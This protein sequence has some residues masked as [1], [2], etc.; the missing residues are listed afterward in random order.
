ME[1][2]KN[3]ALVVGATGITGNNLAQ[4]LISQ[5]WTT[6]GI[7]RNTNTN[8]EGL[9]PVKADLLD[10]QSLETALENI[11]PT[12]IFFTTWMRNDTICKL[13]SCFQ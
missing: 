9:I 2:N 12:H 11:S 6:Y 10:V 7:S 8:I 5:G 4:E 13:L 1:N 3:I